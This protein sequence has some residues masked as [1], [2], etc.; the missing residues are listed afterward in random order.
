MY[1]HNNKKNRDVLQGHQVLEWTPHSGLHWL[2]LLA[3]LP[4]QIVLAAP[5]SGLHWLALL[6]AL[7][8]QALAA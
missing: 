8:P 7:P 5:H 6:A 1:E 3:A 2:E 4:P